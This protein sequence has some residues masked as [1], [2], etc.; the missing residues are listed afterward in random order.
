MLSCATSKNFRGRS[1]PS[2]HTASFKYAAIRSAYAVVNES[3][4]TSTSLQPYARACSE[5]VSVSFISERMF[6]VVRNPADASRIF[7]SASRSI[8]PPA[9]RYMRSL[10][11][12]RRGGHLKQWVHSLS[13]FFRQSKSILLECRRVRRCVSASPLHER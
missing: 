1:A 2:A 11:E 12:K 10:Y 3:W 8:L 9:L 7:T 5:N 13:K 6:C 4:G